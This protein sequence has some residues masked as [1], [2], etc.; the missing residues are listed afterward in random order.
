V[1]TPLCA[2]AEEANG[3]VGKADVAV[4]RGLERAGPAALEAMQAK[5]PTL[6]RFVN[7]WQMNTDGN[8]RELLPQ[9]GH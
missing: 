6:A 1:A 4:Q 2:E 7:G 8:V 3:V 5:I 9:A